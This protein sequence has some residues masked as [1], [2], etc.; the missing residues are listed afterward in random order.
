MVLKEVNMFEYIKKKSFKVVLLQRRDTQ[1]TQK[2]M[3][4]SNLTFHLMK[5]L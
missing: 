2:L 4:W 5:N 3:A 1:D